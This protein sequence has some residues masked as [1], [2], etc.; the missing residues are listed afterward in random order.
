MLFPKYIQISKGASV[1]DLKLK[2]L[3]ILSGYFKIE[4]ESKFELYIKQFEST[5][6]KKEIYNMIQAY[7][8]KCKNFKTAIE[9]LSDDNIFIE[10]SYKVIYFQNLA[11]S[12]GDLIIA[13]FSNFIQI[14]SQI[15]T[16]N[17]CG[18]SLA[19][20]VSCLKCTHVFIF[21]FNQNIYCSEDC[22]NKDL[23]HLNFHTRLAS[24]MKK[25]VDFNGLIEKDIN[26]L[27]EKGS[28]RG[29]TG[30]KNLGNTCFMNSALQCLSNCEPLTIY[31][32]L[33]L[34]KE[35]INKSNSL[36]TKGEIANAYFELIKE[37]WQG[38]S[39]YLCPTDFRQ[40]FVRFVK[41]FAGFSQHDSHEMLTFM[42]D[43]LHEDLN[44]IKKKPY[45]EMKERLSNENDEDASKR[46][47]NNHLLRENSIIVDLFHGQY[48]SVITCPS[49]NHISIT[50][51]PFMYLGLPIPNVH[52]K[53]KFKFFPYEDELKFNFTE[54]E[55]PINEH[56]TVKEMKKYINF[57]NIHSDSIQAVCLTK[58]KG[59]KRIVDDDEFIFNFFNNGEE[60]AIYERHSKS[61]KFS[62][63]QFQTF[64]FVPAEFTVGRNYLLISKQTQKI[65]S[66]P[67]AVTL[68]KNSPIKELYIQVFKLIRKIL[69]DKDRS[70][71]FQKFKENVNNK[72]YLD[73]EFNYYFDNKNIE[74]GPFRLHFIY[75][76]PENPGF[77]SSRLNCE[78]CGTKCEA[79]KVLNKFSLKDPVSAIEDKVT[80][81]RQLAI[82]IEIN[83]SIGQLYNNLDMNSSLK[84]KNLITKQSEVDIYDC[85]NMFRTEERL[86]K[87]NAW[88]CPVCK[89]HR[90]ALKK[91]DIYKPPNILIIQMK[92]FKIKTNNVVMGMIS[93]KKNDS[94]INYPLEGLNL[95]SYVVGP[96]SENSIYD[97]FA[98]SQHYGSLSSGHYTAL[99]RNGNSWY[100][101]DDHSLGRSSTEN[102]VSNAA[103]MLFYKKRSLNNLK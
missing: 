11:F 60:V 95:Q 53:V 37:L 39:S 71:S 67:L 32:L 43:A 70:H 8:N 82:Y 66:Y 79:C 50:Y 47:W 44:R 100:E 91:L 85:L 64:Y 18:Q 30:L 40:I 13:D 24:L 86:E 14:N 88:Y 2:V 7:E 31:F 16:C 99:C 15:K 54:I 25:K 57:Q 72:E 65:I 38:R 52:I 22:R 101:Y 36:G 62:E 75:N 26:E 55:M 103:Y 35:E 34:Y 17:N 45:V 74:E 87:D 21:L 97:L 10:V 63:K 6:Q 58:E 59:F 90:E 56:S 9:K 94:T 20:F 81:T 61:I 12:P 29:L 77:F 5:D 42:L 4:D 96:Q 93:N 27:I 73:S 28:R 102:V 1:R 78:F 69:P 76:I 98:I 83:E 19:T 33:N 84:V 48:K 23:D 51:D 41:Q 3:R 68:H 89:E 49:C 92:R 80:T 46:W